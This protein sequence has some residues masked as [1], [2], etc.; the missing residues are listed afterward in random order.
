MRNILTLIQFSIVW[1]LGRIAKSSPYDA[2]L[3]VFI[4]GSQSPGGRGL[5]FHDLEKLF[6]LGMG[7]VCD[8]ERTYR[9]PIVEYVEDRL[10][11]NAPGNGIQCQ[12]G[13]VCTGQVRHVYK[14][15]KICMSFRLG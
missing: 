7:N 9:I 11:P 8:Y 14:K 2:N 6:T 10:S 3:Y 1:D 13:P 15:N 5:A 12:N 4:T